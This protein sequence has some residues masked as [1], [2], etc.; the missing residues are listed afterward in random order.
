MG[1]VN[2]IAAKYFGVYYLSG[3]VYFYRALNIYTQ[4]QQS[5][6]RYDMVAA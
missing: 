5:A 4:L 3:Q 2:R 1:S 6:S